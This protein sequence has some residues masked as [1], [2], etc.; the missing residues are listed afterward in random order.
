MVEARVGGRFKMYSGKV[1]G[2]IEEL[3]PSGHLKCKWRMAD[4]P[5]GLFSTLRIDIHD[6]EP[7][8]G[9]HLGL[10]QE[11]IPAQCV[12]SVRQHWRELVFN[13]IKRTFGF[14]NIAGDQPIV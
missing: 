7:G 10:V 3:D 13:Q 12:D 9:C 6:R 1:T 5:P 11:G 4:W 8:E 2:G 14:G